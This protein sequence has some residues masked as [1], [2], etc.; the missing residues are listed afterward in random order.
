MKTF[1]LKFFTHIQM[2]SRQSTSSN[3]IASNNDIIKLARDKVEEWVRSGKDIDHYA[4]ILIS[5]IT[6]EHLTQDKEL[7][8]SDKCELALNTASRVVHCAQV[9]R[10]ISVDAAEKIKKFIANRDDIIDLIRVFSIL[11]KE[12]NVIND[13]WVEK[14]EKKKEKKEK[15]EKEEKEEKKEKRSL[16]S[17]K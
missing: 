10:Y 13:K 4:V 14:K 6:V 17:R 9:Q 11:S 12:P 3:Q 2:A 5:M 8:S 7:N 16:F 1:T 15:K